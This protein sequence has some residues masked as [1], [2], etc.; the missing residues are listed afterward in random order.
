MVVD[1]NCLGEYRD[2]FDFI[3]CLENIKNDYSG[4]SMIWTDD[5][6]FFLSKIKP[7][8]YNILDDLVQKDDI[9]GQK[10]VIEQ[11]FEVI[12]VIYNQIDTSKIDI[13][14]EF[15]VINN[16]LKDFN[17]YDDVRTQLN[18]LKT[19]TEQCNIYDK[20]QVEKEDKKVEEREE[21]LTKYD[22][23]FLRD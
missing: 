21:K 5:I 13:L 17:I 8:L 3:Q 2:R 7:L 9:V 18:I 12:M 1:F 19:V 11:V 20:R 15:N 10:S 14:E 16:L 23:Q 22:F 6:C 4:K